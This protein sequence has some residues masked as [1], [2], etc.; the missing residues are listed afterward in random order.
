M[1]T[2][3]EI[4]AIINSDPQHVTTATPAALLDY[5]ATL[6]QHPDIKNIRESNSWG[7]LCDVELTDEDANALIEMWL[8]DDAGTVLESAWMRA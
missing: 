5:D 1:K 4:A 2:L 7:D 8:G 3:A 6:E